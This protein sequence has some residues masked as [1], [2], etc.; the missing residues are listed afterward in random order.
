MQGGNILQSH[1]LLGGKT[2]FHQCWAACSK[3]KSSRCPHCQHNV[4]C[5]PSWQYASLQLCWLMQHKVDTGAAAHGA[6]TAAF[7]KL[8]PGAVHNC[9]SEPCLREEVGDRIQPRVERGPRGR[10]LQQPHAAQRHQRYQRRQRPPGQCCISARLST[11]IRPYNS[12]GWHIFVN[13]SRIQ[14]VGREIFGPR[15]LFCGHFA[16]QCEQHSRQHIFLSSVGPS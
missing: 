13:Y 3:H 8:H 11:G 9:P 6:R 16:F 10:A 14:N 2:R 15:F 12:W 4:H 7:C 1:G 5:V